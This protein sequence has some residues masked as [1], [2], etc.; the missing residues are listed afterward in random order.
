MYWLVVWNMLYLSIQLGIIIPFD[1]YIFQRG[2][3][4]TNQIWSPWSLFRNVYIYTYIHISY[5]IIYMIY[6]YI[7]YIY[8]Y[9]IYIYGT[10]SGHHGHCFE[11]MM[12]HDFPLAFLAGSRRNRYCWSQDAVFLG[13]VN[14]EWEL[15]SERCFFF[16]F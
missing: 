4:T 9:I 10:I 1:F 11:N 7:S 13:M 16:F 8:V 3:Y 2:R 12:D 6:I 15:T 14:A 5:H